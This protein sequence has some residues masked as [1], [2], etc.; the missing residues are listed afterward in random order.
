M[1]LN[2]IRTALRYNREYVCIS[3]LFKKTRWWQASRYASSSK[4]II[5]TFDP[6][7]AA[8]LHADL[9]ASDR[10][11]KQGAKRLPQDPDPIGK[12]SKRLG[13]EL[14]STQGKNGKS[15][16]TGQDCTPK[17]LEGGSPPSPIS[18]TALGR[19]G[20][21][22]DS[23]GAVATSIGSGEAK[24]KKSPNRERAKVS[25]HKRLKGTARNDDTEAEDHIHRG[26]NAFSPQPGTKE[27]HGAST[28]PIAEA[29]DLS[30][31]QTEN[32][33]VSGT[34]VVSYRKVR[35][36]RLI[37]YPASSKGFRVRRSQQQTGIE[38]A[39]VGGEDQVING[40]LAAPE[41]DRQ[42]MQQQQSDSS[43]PIQHYISGQ[44]PQISKIR[45]SLPGA[46]KEAYTEISGARE[47]VIWVIPP[48]FLV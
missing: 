28:E 31:L 6:S 4:S 26:T 33:K 22:L 42:R 11:F 7:F 8:A 32:G 20:N 12:K 10:K 2:P 17:Q 13:T 5:P 29:E 15:D 38:S 41:V 27:R 36:R 1:N 21:L 48:F 45:Q 46:R 18:G 40:E 39:E 44:R 43:A 47:E 9:E 37:K 19:V 16:S 24:P 35:G 25:I 30:T 3:C 14:G 23:P 34:A